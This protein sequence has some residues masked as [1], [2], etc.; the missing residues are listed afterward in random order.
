MRV[1]TKQL[2]ELQEIQLDK[3]TADNTLKIALAYH[4]NCHNQVIKREEL[5]WEEIREI[6]ELDL[7]TKIS[8]S[9]DGNLI[10]GKNKNTD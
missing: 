5:L 6:H 4:S 8:V 9:L 10:I 2:K 7:E 3:T 1:S